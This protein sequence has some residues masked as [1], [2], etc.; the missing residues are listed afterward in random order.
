MRLLVVFDD[1]SERKKIEHALRDS[2]KSFKEIIEYAPI[3]MAIVSLRG[4]FDIVN[5]TLCNIVGYSNRELLKL[6]FQE[7][8]HP[9][10][11]ST[12]L[13]FVR[14]LI[15]GET[16]SYQMEK[17]YVR[18]DKEIVWVQLSVSIFRDEDDAAQY[19]IAQI[20]DITERKIRDNEVHQHAYFDTLTKLPNRRMLMDRLSQEL[21]QA[22]RDNHTVALFFLD[23]DHFKHI[24]DTLGHD[25]GDLI[26][27]ETASRLLSC[28]RPNDMVSRLGGD[29]FVILLSEISDASDAEI[30][31]KKILRKFEEPITVNDKEVVIGTSIGVA[32]RTRDVK[33]TFKQLM[34]NA[35]M[36]M[37]ESKASGRNRYYFYNAA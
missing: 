21:S 17:R 37:Y 23:L 19:F 26:L 22:E 9:E 2:E 28:V 6:T 32:L 27:K 3:G 34:K 36:A 29:E 12:D 35:D 5:Q 33:I 30:V 31:A 8:T 14:Q 1:I 20:E 15:D 25:V 18:K 24:N 10:D 7:I 16:N 11:L 4:R 13:E